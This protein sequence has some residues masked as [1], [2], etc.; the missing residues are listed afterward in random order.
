MLS[1]PFC[2]RDLEAALVN[3]GQRRVLFDD[4]VNDFTRSSRSD[5]IKT[6]ASRVLHHEF[7]KWFYLAIS[8]L[9]FFALITSFCHKW[10]TA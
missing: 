3:N 2:D 10:Y 8:I 7:Y 5:R 9:S 4:G 1:S 6:V